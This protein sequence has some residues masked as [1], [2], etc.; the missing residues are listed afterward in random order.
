MI[1]I[2]DPIAAEILENHE[3]SDRSKEKI[4]IVIVETLIAELS[5]LGS[6]YETAETLKS[7]AYYNDTIVKNALEHIEPGHHHDGD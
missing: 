7:S 4:L 6:E 3:L 1:S 5:D 2:F